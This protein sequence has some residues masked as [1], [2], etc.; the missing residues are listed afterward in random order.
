MARNPEICDGIDN[1]CSGFEDDIDEDND[2]Y[3]P[4]PGGDC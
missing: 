3:P 4:C 2:G 1:N